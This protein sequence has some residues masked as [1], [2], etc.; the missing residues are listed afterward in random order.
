MTDAI[1][2]HSAPIAAYMSVHQA[3]NLAY[4]RYFAK[5]DNATTA[6]FKSLDSKTFTLDYTL[7]NDT[8]VHTVSIPFKAPLQKRE[9]IRPV[10]EAMAKEAEESLGLP[11]SLSGPPPFAAIAKAI[12]ASATDV[13]TPPQP[14]VPL[15]TFYSPPTPVMCVM[16]LAVGMIG[17]F[18][19]ASDAYL[20]RQFPAQVLGLRNTF[21]PELVLKITKGVI[22]V[23]LAE[24]L[25]TLTVCLHRGWYGPVN[26]LKWVAS[27]FLCGVASIQQLNRHAKHVV[28]L[29]KKSE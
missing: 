4:V 29:N 2:P 28:G 3:T 20:Q 5:I 18:T 24:S 26:T 6:T 8:T 19:Y 1:A 17:V 15:D 21:G 27:T 22:A 9:D 16:G 12:V 25:Y 7:P 14:Q 23:H 13:Y 10:L 11:S